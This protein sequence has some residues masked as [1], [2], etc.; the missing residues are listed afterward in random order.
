MFLENII[1]N[2]QLYF[3]IFARIFALVSI[4]P[5][6]SSNSLPGMARAALALFTAVAVFPWVAETGYAIPQSGLAYTAL[7]IGEILIG[8]LTGFF[9]QLIYSVF[10]TAG[11][12]F[13]LQMGFGASVVFDPLAQVEIPL[14]GQL[15]NNFAMFVF[16]ASGGFYKIFLVGVYRS[17][18]SL[19]AY[20][21]LTGREYVFAMTINGVGRLFEQAM[22]IA[23]PILGSLFLVSLSMGLLAKA[24]P[25]MNLLMMG[26]PVSIIV[27]YVIM[28]LALPFIIKAFVEIL[29]DSFFQILKWYSTYGAL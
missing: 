26:F 28:L 10:I 17:F 2:A 21:F 6:I 4:A 9:L 25:Q 7:L 24:A 14:L 22:I 19:N 16:I 13:S 3:L 12:F 29:D 18:Q 20:T 8:I 23:L 27:A 1:E 5:L 11:Q 15:F